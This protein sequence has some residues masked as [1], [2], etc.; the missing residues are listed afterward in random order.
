MMTT[1]FGKKSARRVDMIY[2]EFVSLLYHCIGFIMGGFVILSCLKGL[3][4]PWSVACVTAM[5]PQK[6]A[7]RADGIF[8]FEGF[9]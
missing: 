3:R 8:Y 2:L 4:R 1:T 6:S 5:Y 7:L 9:T